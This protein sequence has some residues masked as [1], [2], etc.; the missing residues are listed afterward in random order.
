MR[1]LLCCTVAALVVGVVAV[2]VSG[3]ERVED[4]VDRLRRV[5]REQG[6]QLVELEAKMAAIQ[7]ATADQVRAVMAEMGA[8]PEGNPNDFVAY[9]DNGIRL[10]TLDG[11]VKI[12][13]GGRFMGDA[14]WVSDT[15]LEDALDED[16]EDCV[17]TRRFRFYASGNI[18]K[19]ME[20]KVQ[21][22]LAGD[23]PSL[24]DAYLKWK[25][26]PAV[27]SVTV[28]HFKEPFSLEEL[29]SS[30]YTTFI[31][32]ALP[33]E[34]FAPSRNYGVMAAD[35]VG[36]NLWWAVGVFKDYGSNE[37]ECEDGEYNMSARVAWAPWYAEGGKQLLHVGAAYSLRHFDGTSG[38]RYR[39]RPEAHFMPRLVDTGT[40]SFTDWAHLF[41]GEVAL[42]Y[43]PFSVQGEYIGA[44]L[45]QDGGQPGSFCLGGGYVYASYFLTGENRKYKN[46]A[47]SRVKPDKNWCEPGG[48]GAWEVAA[49]YSCLDLMEGGLG[50]DRGRMQDVTVGLNWYLN[51]NM[52]VMWNYIHSCVDRSDFDDEADILLMRVQV[53]F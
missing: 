35:G 27:G 41:G 5:V 44:Y 42:V 6:R 30:K 10:K 51:P 48:Y 43:G 15:S 1:K 7:G 50:D 39:S 34:A 29:T 11:S 26:L 14:G 3:D 25:K 46:G 21:V 12:K 37:A 8:G 24:K 17:E 32:R 22:D 4:R 31:E 9:W 20:F 28:G 33:V 38:P 16:L 47:F 23:E 49:R 18:T 19:C 2:R 36:D 53:D 40:I 45:N 52:R 13:L